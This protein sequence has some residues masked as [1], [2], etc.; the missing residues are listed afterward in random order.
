MN[1]IV[2]LCLAAG[3]AALLSLP[4]GAEDVRA[5]EV[6]LLIFQN[7]VPADGGEIW[8][9]DYSQWF[10]E[11]AG[12]QGGPHARVTWLD[13]QGRTLTSERNALGRSANYR[14]LAYLAWRQPVYDRNT[15]LPVEIPIRKSRTGTY[16][17][18]TARVAVERYL[19]LD[20]DL[21]L[22]LA[23]ADA[24]PELA[25]GDRVKIR[26]KESRRMRSRELHYFDNPRFGVIALVT[27]VAAASPA[28]DPP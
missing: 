4:A 21:Q 2:A 13:T 22:R 10:E 1:R 16:V 20:L 28:G 17:E 19:H 27:P 14:P 18:G 3:I 24:P 9:L 5:Y 12:A 11:D 23:G 26:L 15:A 7:L 8:P 6:E 25:A